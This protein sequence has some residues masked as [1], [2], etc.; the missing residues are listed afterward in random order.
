MKLLDFHPCPSPCPSRFLGGNGKGKGKGA[1]AGSA[2]IVSA[3]ITILAGC[4]A[5]RPVL[6]PNETL[7]RVGST[8][9]QQDVD[10][11]LE[12]AKQYLASDGGKG[13]QVAG[14]VAKG[15]VVGAGTGA[16]VGAVGGAITGNPGEGAAV[17]AA[18]GA[19]AGVL[20][21]LFGAF[22]RRSE[23]DPTYARFVERCL[24][25]KGYDVI[26]WE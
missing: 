18:S 17:G 9:A 26:G 13:G 25:D 3:L 6:Y 11:C 23:P 19:T 2:M 20:G 7:Q 21:G 12:Q 8:A 14:D 16:A 4:G 5:H 22:G 15:T 24:R 1:S 10:A